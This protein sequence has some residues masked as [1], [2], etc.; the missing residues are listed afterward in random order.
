MKSLTAAMGRMFA[1]LRFRLLALVLLV[2]APL[3]LLMLHAAGEDRRRAVADWRA[4]A[5][6]LQLLASRDE[7]ELIGSTRQLLLAISESAYVRSLDPRRCKKGL[8]DLF[9][10]YPRFANLGVLTTNGQVLVCARPSLS[11]ILADRAFVQ[12]AIATR[13]FTIGSFPSAIGRPT[14]SFGF[15]VLDHAGKLL[16]VVFAELDLQY[17]DRF[18]TE[19]PAQLPRGATWT[20][21]DRSGVVLARYPGDQSCI[22]KVF[23]DAEL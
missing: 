21:L 1:G 7:D 8:D 18:G 10:S 11:E 20:E 19:V 12:E 15:P 16:A 4:Q 23:S 17:F 2:C 3:L 22:G 5:Q 13:A 9:A 6:N 14:I